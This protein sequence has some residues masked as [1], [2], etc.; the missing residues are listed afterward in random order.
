MRKIQKVAVLA[1][2][3]G[4]IGFAGAGTAFAGGGDP[5]VDVHQ[6]TVCK[7]HDLNVDILG[8]VGILNGVAGNVLGGEGNPGG[9][10]TGLGS[11]LGCNES[12]F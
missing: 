5:Y 11:S 8:E 12:A 1:A 9:Q 4:S 3:L 10:A 2:M 7:S 6:S